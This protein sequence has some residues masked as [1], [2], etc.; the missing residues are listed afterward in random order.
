MRTLVW[1]T[2]SFRLNSRL[3]ASLKGE[4]TFLYYSPFYFAG[5]R[6][7]QMYKDCSKTNLELF[8]ASL[9][10]FAAELKAEC[11][12]N[13]HIFKVA[14]PIVHLAGLIAKHQYTHLVI[15]RPL[16][17]LWTSLSM[18]SLA[19]LPVDIS[20]VD[21]ALIDTDC[22][23][24]TAK[25]RWMTHVKN[26][27]A[28]VPYTFSAKIQAFNIGDDGA[29][30]PEVTTI[31][32]SIDI[33]KLLDRAFKIAPSYIDTRDRHDGQTRLST[34]LHN[35]VLDPRDV[36][37]KM[38]KYFKAN[39]ISLDANEGAGASMLRQFA[40]RDIAIIR[41]RRADL[42]L[43]SSDLEI[44]KALL[45]TA[46]FDNLIQQK[47]G[48]TVTFEKIKAGKTGVREIDVLLR[49][50]LKTGIMPNRARMVFASLVFY[51]SP[52]GVDAL[53]TLLKTFDLIGIDG[54]SPNN[55][56]GVC[57]SLELSYGKV[58][59][60]NPDTAFKKLYG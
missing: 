47:P 39:G 33:R 3:T 10:T 32:E 56:V 29:S 35:G 26:V 20:V 17:A 2:N 34:A 49:D 31:H 55:M 30:Y 23:K 11:G 43:E 44:A 18:A 58:L 14:D 9:N 48:G 28:Y 5:A 40:F 19:S 57:G 6:E 13:L 46:S 4:C 22:Q 25:S 50:F 12:A 27:D 54:Q 51:N 59:K 53:S 52:T 45:P 1:L 36:F 42:T 37:F 24:M 41:V 21:S 16:F 15:D 8:Y 7:R 38:A 60:M